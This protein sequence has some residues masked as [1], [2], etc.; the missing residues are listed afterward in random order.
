[1]EIKILDWI[2][3]LRTPILDQVMRFITTLGNAGI[4]WIAL[5]I[6]LLVIPKTRKTGSIVTA[7]LVINII[8]VNLI[9]KNVFARVRPCDVNTAI[10][11]LVSRPTD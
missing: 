2:Q 5:A 10:Q 3:T 1:M 11:L 8:V 9:L 7:S 4:I 6:I